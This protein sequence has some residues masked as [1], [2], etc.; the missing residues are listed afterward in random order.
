LTLSSC[1]Q[2]VST[3]RHQTAEKL[4]V[5]EAS[6]VYQKMT[7][8]ICDCTLS[9]MKNNKPSTSL[10]SCYAVVLDKYTD[11]L[12]DLGYDPVSSE[13]L[14]KLLKEVKV[15]QCQD[16][17]SLMQKEW[18]DKEANK[19]LFKGEF[20]SQKK[21]A[22]GEYEV[23]FKE[24]KTKEQKVFKAKYPFDVGPAKNF[25]PGY[26][27]TIEYEIVKNSITQKDEF[28]IKENAPVIDVEAV[29]VKLKIA[30]YNRSFLNLARGAINSR[31]VNGLKMYYEFINEIRYRAIQ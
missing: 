2:M 12:K 15:Y 14:I 24:S 18:S 19:L 3:D 16:L 5:Q 8:E 1:G 29:P 7:G 28:Y 31:I 26:E 6:A 9:T 27:I 22:T 20:I 13:G 23:T 21:L 11:T 17:Y 10:D 30:V 25:R 4:K